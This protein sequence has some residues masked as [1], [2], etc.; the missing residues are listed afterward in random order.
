MG[1]PRTLHCRSLPTGKQQTN[2]DGSSAIH[3]V[4]QGSEVDLLNV[5]S[6]IRALGGILRDEL[7][8]LI[9]GIKK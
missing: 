9:F 3:H 4:P 7:L 1:G 2:G 6:E 5:P 8:F